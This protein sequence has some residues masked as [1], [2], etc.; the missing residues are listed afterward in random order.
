MPTGDAARIETGDSYVARNLFGHEEWI[1]N[2]EWIIDGFRY[3][4]LQPW[5]QVPNA[6]FEID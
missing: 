1:F 5:F 2:F 6:T 3:G 4:F